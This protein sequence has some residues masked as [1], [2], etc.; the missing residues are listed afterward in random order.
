M[1]HST[2][3]V[4][5][6]PLELSLEP[7]TPN[8][9]KKRQRPGRKQLTSHEKISIIQFHASGLS[10]REIGRRL[11]RNHKI[12]SH[13]VKNW[14][15]KNDIK[16]ATG[17]GRPRKTSPQTDR[18]IRR[19]I[20]TN[21]FSSI[22]DLMLCPVLTNLSRQT[23]NRRVTEKGDFKSYW[24]SKKP[25]IT[26]INKAKRLAWCQAR[27]NWSVEQ[28]STFLW[29]DESP[30]VLRYKAKRRVWRRHNERYNDACVVRTVKHDIKINVWGCFS[31][32]GV[33]SIAL[34]DGILDQYQYMDILENEML[35]SAQNL[36]ADGPWTFQQ[37]NDPKHTAINTR[38]WFINHQVPLSEW[39]AQSPDLNPIENLWSILDKRCAKR[40]PNTAAE[41]FQSLEEEWY[42]LPT[43][44][45]TTLVHSMPRR[46]RAVIDADGGMTKY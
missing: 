13:V 29:T 5:D 32:H 22:S 38:N 12:I 1:S 16:R 44:L 35:P 20:M 33:G 21:R 9:A 10:F 30:Y 36:F 3:T 34:V 8:N 45:L 42:Q 31:A 40:A 11:D 23:I 6:M 15:A 46:C 27:I 37:D 28:W 7:A 4:L 43:D 17:S 18:M 25:L 41:L 39:P 24:A 26:E 19:I 14:H 2:T